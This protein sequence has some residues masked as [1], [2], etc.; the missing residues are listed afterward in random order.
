MKTRTPEI[1]IPI[2]PLDHIFVVPAGKENSRKD[3]WE[4]MV[5]S[6]TP[7]GNPKVRAFSAGQLGVTVQTVTQYAR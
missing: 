1:V 2:R 5:V 6:F 4:A 3:W 7:N